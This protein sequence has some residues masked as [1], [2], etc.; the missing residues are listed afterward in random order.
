MGLLH[1]QSS[2][3]L[4]RTLGLIAAVPHLHQSRTRGSKAQC[5]ASIG[6][7][8]RLTKKRFPFLHTPG[9]T[10]RVHLSRDYPHKI[11]SLT[12][13]C[14][15][16]LVT[17]FTANACTITHYVHDDYA[18]Y[19]LNNHGTADL[20]STSKGKQYFITP[21][22]RQFHYEFRA[23]A[24]GYANLWVVDFGQML[25]DT[26]KSKDVQKAFH[27]FLAATETSAPL[28]ETLTFDL[29]QYSF[30]D[31]HANVSLHISLQQNGKVAF[32][33]LYTEIGRA[34]AG[35]MVFG[36]AFAQRNAV[37]QST[38]LAMDAILRRLIADLNAIPPSTPAP[39]PHA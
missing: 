9:H 34:Q 18:Q 16:A 27:G 36:G 30:E 37:H 23:F 19:L 11:T 20:P 28:A 7:R 4:N 8:R 3:H 38:K 35:K 22:T 5:G 25:D 14:W 21:K 33:K 13:Q 6:R 24:T 29:K 32:S 10:S 12:V 17:L 31:Y 39:T 1:C 26:L 15:L 2:V